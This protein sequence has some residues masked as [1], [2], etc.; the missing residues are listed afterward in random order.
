MYITLEALG[1]VTY[2]KSVKGYIL[3]YLCIWSIYKDLFSL[4]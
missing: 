1:D 2:I 3:K 4:E